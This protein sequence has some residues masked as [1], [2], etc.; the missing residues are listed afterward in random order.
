M[1]ADHHTEAVPVMLLKKKLT[2]LTPVKMDHSKL[3]CFHSFC[4]WHKFHSETKWLQLITSLN[5]LISEVHHN[6][7]SL[8]SNHASVSVQCQAASRVCT[9]KTHPH[10]PKFCTTAYPRFAWIEVKLLHPVIQSDIN[11]VKGFENIFPFGEVG[12][13]YDL[14]CLLMCN[15]NKQLGHIC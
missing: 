12:I 9:T 10:P 13:F 5:T 15:S 11:L 7:L 3:V 8:L 2:F 6:N 14:T 1:S 4:G